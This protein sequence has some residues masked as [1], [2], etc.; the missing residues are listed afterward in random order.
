M[1]KIRVM[2]VEDSPVVQSLLTEILESDDQIEVTSVVGSGEEA[3]DSIKREKPDLI[4]LDIQLPKMDGL[5]FTNYVMRE[6]PIPIVVVSAVSETSS[7]VKAF[8]LLKAGALAA[9]EKPVGLGH[10]DYKRLKGQLISTVKLMAEIKLVT[11][12]DLKEFTRAKEDKNKDNSSDRTEHLVVAVG[13]STGGPTVIQQVL[14]NLPRDFPVPIV[15]A[16]HIAEGFVDGFVSWLRSTTAYKVEVAAHMQRLK[17]STAYVCPDGYQTSLTAPGSLIV[18]ERRYVNGVRPSVSVLFDSVAKSFGN[19]G[20]GVLLS[21]MGKDGAPELK[22]IKEKGGIT[23]AQDQK[24]SIVHG[25][26]GEA[27]KLGA[28]DHIASAESIAKLLVEIT[29]RDRGNS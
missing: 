17:P 13:A 11:R 28:A 9:I 6:F 27:I 25:M 21:G 19:R 1:E 22:L 12:R 5:D 20:I 14:K 3:L 10:E 7:V 18:K 26:P 29:D 23:I 4:T 16:Q 15:I 24:S 8:D 2:I